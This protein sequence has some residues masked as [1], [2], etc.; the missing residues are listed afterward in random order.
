MSKIS[1]ILYSKV[2]FISHLLIPQNYILGNNF[3]FF[4]LSKED[5]VR[6]EGFKE[7]FS[8]VYTWK[9]KL[10]ISGFKYPI[11][12]YTYN[13]VFQKF[14]F[15]FLSTIYCNGKYSSAAVCTVKG[16]FLIYYRGIVCF[17]G[18]GQIQW[19][20]PSFFSFS[21]KIKIAKPSKKA[22]F[23]F[24]IQGIKSKDML[25]K[26]YTTFLYFHGE[27]LAISLGKKKK[28]L[29]SLHLL[30]ASYYPEHVIKEAQKFLREKRKGKISKEKLN[31]NKKPV[32][33]ILTKNSVK[34]DK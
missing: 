23:F 26:F 6:K 22:M 15:S 19:F 2:F 17:L 12:G 10:I 33:K 27:S 4:S 18:K 5:F 28:G 32:K 13:P 31:D 29:K 25:Y 3:F 8:S 7:G 9:E 34:K 1:N 16:G 30:S 14:F 20:L 11:L 21:S 24:F